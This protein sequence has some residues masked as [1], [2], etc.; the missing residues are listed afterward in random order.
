MP[1]LAGSLFFGG[2]DHFAF[3]D[4]KQGDIEEIA[5]VIRQNRNQRAAAVGKFRG[6]A[7]DSIDQMAPVGNFGPGIFQIF[8]VHMNFLFFL[9]FDQER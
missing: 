7:G 9:P 5:V 8:F 4:F 1:A 2:N 6:P 3:G